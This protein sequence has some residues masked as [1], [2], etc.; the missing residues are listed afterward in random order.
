MVIRNKNATLV[1]LGDIGRSP[2]MCYHAKSL[3]DKNYRVQIVGYADHLPHPTI[4]EH[5]NIRIIALRPPPASLNNLR[6]AFGLF[7]K[8]FWTLATLL[9]A[10]FFRIDWPLLILMQ[11]PPG[12]PCMLAC[13]IVGCFR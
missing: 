5:P 3:A 8:F 12:V 1:V 7:L 11:N 9:F 2:R 13:W 6:P 10:L 4:S